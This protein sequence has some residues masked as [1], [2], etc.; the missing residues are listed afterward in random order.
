LERL[1]SRD[2][3][4]TQGLP[5]RD[6]CSRCATLL[7]VTLPC[8]DLPHYAWPNCA[9]AQLGE[10]AGKREKYLASDLPLGSHVNA[11]E[12]GP[13]QSLLQRGVASPLSHSELHHLN[14]GDSLSAER[15]VGRQ[16]QE[17]WFG[18]LVGES[19][20]MDWLVT[21]SLASVFQVTAGLL[22]ASGVWLTKMPDR[23][24]PQAWTSLKVQKLA[25]SSVQAV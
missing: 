7:C 1:G 14:A 18:V 15:M 19:T 23:P 6:A 8:T 4:I 25:V 2:G 9:P 11:T 20:P 12:N 3:S 21:S 17:N 16:E 22:P 13:S 5:K 24:F 10:E